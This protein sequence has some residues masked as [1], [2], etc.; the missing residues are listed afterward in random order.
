M[1]PPYWI[2]VKLCRLYCYL[3][4]L[5][6]FDV[7][8]FRSVRRSGQVLDR[9]ARPH[10]VL[11]HAVSVTRGFAF[12]RTLRTTEY[13]APQPGHHRIR[14]ATEGAPPNTGRHQRG[15]TEYGYGPQR[16][17][18]APPNIYGASGAGHHRIRRAVTEGAPPSTG[19]NRGGTTEYGA[20][21]TVGAP[22]NTG[23]P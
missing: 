2:Y 13:G 4:P 1:I 7:S 10:A 6:D 17:V 15:T 20:P 22:P 18:G 19:R 9:S 14:A 3:R 12:G 16:A 5:F 21:Y 23:R 11:R 8:M